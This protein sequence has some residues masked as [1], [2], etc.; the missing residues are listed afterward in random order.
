MTIM[1]S[2]F[3]I[4]STFSDTKVIMTLD[5][6]FTVSP[7]KSHHFFETRETAMPVSRYS[8]SGVKFLVVDIAE[9]ATQI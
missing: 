1:I 7:C 2:V 9:M 8:L 6:S 3:T 4:S 5:F